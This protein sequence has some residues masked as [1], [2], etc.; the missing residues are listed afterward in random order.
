MIYVG[1]DDTDTLDDPGT[2]QLARHLVREL[3][4]E[5]S[6]R[7]IVRHQLL[8]DPRVPCTK[9]NGCA[10]MAFEAVGSALPTTPADGGSDKAA[11]RVTPNLVEFIS[12][13]RHIIIPWCPKA[14][15]PGLC[16]TTSV[17]Q[18]VVAW[19]QRCK[20]EL[21]TQ[22]EAR[23]LAAEHGIHLEGLGGT[24]DGVIGALAAVGLMATKNDGRVVHYGSGWE[25]R[26]DI[27]GLLDVSDI[28]SRGVEEIRDFNS[29]QPITS[30]T[31][32]VGKRLRPNY[33][34]GKVVLFAARSDAPHWQAV[35]VT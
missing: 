23:G 13:L 8:E 34:E 31:V 1:L 15:D 25:D 6:G 11:R 22:S 12:R 7:L 19:G 14:S 27:T 2:N 9:K 35:R 4:A 10:S 5:Y 28:L 24:E 32:D 20:R 29:G 21:V 16:V 17:P 30:G 33:R 3:A 26:Y 18:P